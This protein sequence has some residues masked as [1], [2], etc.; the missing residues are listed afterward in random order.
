[1]F[2]QNFIKLS[3]VVHELSCSHRKNWWKQY[4]PSLPCRQYQNVNTSSLLV[5]T[6]FLICTNKAIRCFRQS[7]LGNFMWYLNLVLLKIIKNFAMRQDFSLP[8]LTTTT[9]RTNLNYTTH[10]VGKGK[11]PIVNNATQSSVTLRSVLISAGLVEPAVT[12]KHSSVMKALGQTSAVYRRYVPSDQTGTKLYC[13]VTEAHVCKQ[14]AQGCY[15]P[16]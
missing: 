1:M 8:V 9:T 14:L 5:D 11:S 3:V 7:C 12:C 10:N 16:V 13:L 6:E 15:L 4:S 2:L